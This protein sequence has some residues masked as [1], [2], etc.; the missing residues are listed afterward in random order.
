MRFSIVITTC[1]RLPLLQ[2]AVESALNQSVPCEVAIADDAS[3]DG[4]EAYVKSLGNAVVYHRNQK[5]LGHSAT[6]NAGVA[7]ARG[8]WI[9]LVDDDD[10]LAPDCIER[11]TA[12]IAAFPRTVLCSCQAIQVDADGRTLSHT[13]RIGSSDVFHVLQEDIHYGMLMEKL[14]FGTPIQVAFK[15]EAFLSSRGWNSVFDGNFDDIDSWVR[16][17]SYGDAVFINHP[18]AYRTMW[19]GNGS[20]QFS[21]REQ[22]ERHISIKQELYDF[23]HVK[24]HPHMPQCE[25]MCTFLKLYWGLL[26]MKKGDVGAALQILFPAVFSLP[27]WMYLL[28]LLYRR[29]MEAAFGSTWQIGQPEI[30]EVRG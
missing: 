21:L 24:Y 23:V 26:G 8:D 10:Y 5:N 11:M 30:Q 3:C 4:T 12:A 9:K 20:R 15:K 13:Q 27:A 7:I 6:V 14:P 2:R 22:L 16:I 29:K 28:R 1:N 25:T 19:S 17:A 18:L